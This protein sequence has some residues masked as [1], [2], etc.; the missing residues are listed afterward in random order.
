ME[1]YQ[2]QVFE[3]QRWSDHDQGVVWRHEVALDLVMEEPVID[4]GGG[5][6]LFLD[7][8]RQHKGFRRLSMLD[9]SP[10]AI[11]KAQK[12][13]LDAREADLARPLPFSEGIFGTACALD[14]LEH[15]YNPLVTLREM[16]RLA[17]Y[18]VVVVPNFH[19]WQ[20]RLQ[21]FSGQVPFQC[22]PKRG[23]V[24]WF[25]YPILREMIVEAGLQ[26]DAIVFGGF[27]CLGPVGGCLARWLPNVFAHSFAVRLKKV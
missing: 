25:N 17:R 2:L 19:Y 24:H 14:V 22:K 21:M 3:N 10:V 1:S 11:E 13:G 5:D 8:L 23:H 18:V 4:V 15:L 16:A 9:I 26:V 6:G 27:R 20:G 7:N 12:R